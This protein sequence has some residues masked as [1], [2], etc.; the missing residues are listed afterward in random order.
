VNSITRKFCPETVNSGNS[1]SEEIIGK[2]KKGE[3]KA[4][5]KDSLT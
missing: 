3:K 2:G 4:E 5:R 1:G